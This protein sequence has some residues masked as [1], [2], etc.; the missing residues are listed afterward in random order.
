MQD[1]PE[2]LEACIADIQAVYDRDPACEQYTQCMLYFK[3]RGYEVLKVTMWRGGVCLHGLRM[4]MPMCMLLLAER[5]LEGECCTSTCLHNPVA[6]QSTSAHLPTHPIN[7]P[8]PHWFSRRSTAPPPTHTTKQ[9]T[10]H[11]L[12]PL[13]PCTSF[14]VSLLPRQGFQARSSALSP[15]HSNT[16]PC[17]KS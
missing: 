15:I 4:D 7:I 1:D 10:P 14:P 8:H 13:S 16:T 2:I 3:V 11:T 6:G 9:H 12:P 5:C 17:I